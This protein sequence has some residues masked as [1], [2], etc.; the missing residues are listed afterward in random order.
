VGAA[1]SG[2][3]ETRAFSSQV[4]EWHD[5]DKETQGKFMHWRRA[6]QA[7]APGSRLHPGCCR[8]GTLVGHCDGSWPR[9]YSA[10]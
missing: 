1:T 7:A 9:S 8:P 2:R 5:E 3:V 6:Q 4:A 10:A